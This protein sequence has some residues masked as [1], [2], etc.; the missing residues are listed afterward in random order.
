MIRSSTGRNIW[1]YSLPKSKP[2]PQGSDQIEIG[3]GGRRIGF[4]RSQAKSP[5]S[6][7]QYQQSDRQSG[8]GA[9]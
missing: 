9:G 5:Q 6:H 1:P 2:A 3:A 8:P 7:L 4:V